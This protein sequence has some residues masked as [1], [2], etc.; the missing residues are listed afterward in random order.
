MA[1]EVKIIGK[2]SEWQRAFASVLRYEGGYVNDP[3]DSG[4]ATN[5]G[6]TQGTLDRA[7]AL[8]L[9]AAADVKDLTRSDAERIY[10][11]NYWERF[12]CG[13]YA[14]PV[15]LV[16]F[17]S[18]VQHGAMPLIV[19]RA[20]RALGEEIAADGLWGPK[21]QAASVRQS[22]RGSASFAEEILR[23]RA[24]Y[25]RRIIEHRSDQRCFETGWF[26]R[27]RRLAKDAGVEPPV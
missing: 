10:R 4:G 13:S 17:D 12:G 22:C 6:I 9:V 18:A 2:T 24:V 7:R 26:N 14:W 21:T 3:R 16:I 11:R 27:L 5:L 8:E 1:L 15:N 25:Y 20:L 23:Q 19:Q